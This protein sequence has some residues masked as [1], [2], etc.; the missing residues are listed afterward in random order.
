[1]D[2][3]VPIPPTYDVGDRSWTSSSW[4]N[5]YLQRFDYTSDYQSI[6]ETLQVNILPTTVKSKIYRQHRIC[7]TQ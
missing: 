3:Q 4:Q 7:N 1:M 6:I 5:L 2:T